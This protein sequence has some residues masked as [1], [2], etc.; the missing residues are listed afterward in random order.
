[1]AQ[2]MAELS[3]TV[4]VSSWFWTFENYCGIGGGE[5]DDDKLIY[6]LATTVF[7]NDGHLNEMTSLFPNIMEKAMHLFERG[8]YDAS[9]WGL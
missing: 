4:S 7:Y 8:E 1:M 3:N 2:S 9:Y 5:W 6:N